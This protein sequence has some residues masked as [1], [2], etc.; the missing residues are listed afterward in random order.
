MKRFELAL[1]ILFLIGMVTLVLTW[2]AQ[3]EAQQAVIRAKDTQTLLDRCQ[4]VLMATYPKNEAEITWYMQHSKGCLKA[5]FGLN[6]AKDTVLDT[7]R[8]LAEGQ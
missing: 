2:P 7:I 8:R 5:S 4:S 3:P 6:E 1:S